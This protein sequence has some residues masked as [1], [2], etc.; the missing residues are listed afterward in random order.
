[1]FRWG[2]LTRLWLL[3]WGIITNTA[4]IRHFRR[5][6]RQS[7]PLLITLCF[8]LL[9]GTGVIDY[10][11]GFEMFFSVFYLLGVG[12]AAWFVGRSFGLTMSVLSVLVWV[13]GDLAAGAHYSRPWI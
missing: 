10:L 5:L 9:A 11:T 3:N 2:P 7:L 13:G 8:T 4:M 12:M 1:M 6:E